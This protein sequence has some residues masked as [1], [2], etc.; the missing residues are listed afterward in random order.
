[1]ITLV[2]CYLA[3]KLWQWRGAIA[4]FARTLQQL[5]RQCNLLFHPLPTTLNLKQGNL[6]DLRL[7]YQTLTL[8]LLRLQQILFLI[9]FLTKLPFPI[10]RQR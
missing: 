1:M 9:S 4:I 5:E 2:N 10:S 3:W 6:R 7:S 8:Q